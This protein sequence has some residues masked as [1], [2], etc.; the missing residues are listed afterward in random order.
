MID[1]DTA[2]N[3][4][5]IGGVNIANANRNGFVITNETIC[6]LN[7]M[8]IINHMRDSVCG[9]LSEE[10]VETVFGA[11]NAIADNNLFTEFDCNTKIKNL[12]AQRRCGIT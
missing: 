11:Y 5:I 1:F 7:T 3:K 6:Y 12:I 10:Q 4:L 8:V 2:L 9:C